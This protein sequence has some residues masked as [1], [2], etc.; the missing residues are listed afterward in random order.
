MYK[1]ITELTGISIGWVIL[2][3]EDTIK[4]DHVLLSSLTTKKMPIDELFCLQVSTSPK[5]F[6][7]SS[8]VTNNYLLLLRVEIESD[9]YVRIGIDEIVIEN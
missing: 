1:S 5:A 6:D 4:P 7:G 2:D 8:S 3:E 9:T